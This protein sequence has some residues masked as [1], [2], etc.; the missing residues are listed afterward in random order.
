M[1][2]TSPSAPAAVFPLGPFTPSA[3]NPILEPRGDGWE[4]ANLYNPAAIVVED[5]VVL[6]YRAHGEDLVSRIGLARSRDGLAFTREEEPVLVPEHDY[7]SAGC[8]D[9]RITR[10]DGTF[11]LTYTGYDGHRAQ[12]CL[13]TSS[14]LRTWE[15]H[16]PLFPQFNTWGTLPYGPDGPWSKAGVIWPEPIDGVYVMYFGEGAIYVATSTDLLHWTPCAQDRP[17]HRP[18]ADP[19][20]FDATL[21]EIGAPPVVTAEGLL[22]LLINGAVAQSPHEVDYRCGQLAVAQSDPTRVLAHTD[23]PWLLPTT[24]AETEGLVPSVTFVEGLVH[25]HGRWL[26]Y[27]G[28]ADT[29]LAVAIHDPAQ[30]SYRP[31]D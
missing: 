24:R 9:P 2:H 19:S 31:H 29:R 14:D 20:R 12:L 5:E 1:S 6:L 28:Q 17:I 13:A 11:Y 22:V 27:Y 3:H 30:D 4:S 26:A 10:I 23:V 21:V 16:G 18:S 7:E 8:E 25:F 15:K